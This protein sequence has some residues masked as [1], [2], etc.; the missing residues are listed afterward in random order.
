M[1]KTREMVDWTYEKLCLKTVQALEKNEFTALF[2]PTAVA[3]CE[4]IINEAADADTV[5]IGGSMSL[6]EMKIAD[7]LKERGKTILVSKGPGITPEQGMAIRRRQLT[8]DLF[9][10]GS[11]AVTL[12]GCLVNIDN[13]GNRV[14]PMAFGPRKSIV[15]I[16]RNKIVGG[17]IEMAIKRIKDRA[18]PPNAKRLNYETPCAATGFCN[19]CASPDRICRIITILEKKPKRSDLRILVV[20]QDL[21]Y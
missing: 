15:V 11:N 17:S 8:C 12:S 14:G 5:A 6:A 19:D 7:Q 20:N 18:A 21:G 2:C 13:T 10:C 16:G 4:Y 3:A 1:P 9:L